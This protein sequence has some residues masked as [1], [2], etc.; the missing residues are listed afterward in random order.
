MEMITWRRTNTGRAG[1]REEHLKAEEN[2][3]RDM[4]YEAAQD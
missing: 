4:S 1:Q 2:L 3:G